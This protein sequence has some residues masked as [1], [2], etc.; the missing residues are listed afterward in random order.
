[1]TLAA[2]LQNLID[3][4]YEDTWKS[5]ENVKANA[6]LFG[7]KKKTPSG[8]FFV[9][10]AQFRNVKCWRLLRRRVNI[11]QMMVM[12]A[13]ILFATISFIEAAQSASHHAVRF[14]GCFF[15]L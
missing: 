12:A 15:K 9:L 8:V 1:M 3:K 4:T 10:V 5:F 2:D 6:R 11:N 14:T 13:D 7:I